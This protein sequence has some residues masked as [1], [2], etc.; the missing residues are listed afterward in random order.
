VEKIKSG[1]NKN[2]KT[3]KQK[4]EAFIENQKKIQE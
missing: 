1:K 4:K 3:K 2:K